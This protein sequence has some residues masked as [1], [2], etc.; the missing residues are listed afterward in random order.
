MQISNEVAKEKARQRAETAR[1]WQHKL[2]M[3]NKEG[4][5]KELAQLEYEKQQTLAKLKDNE[6]ARLD[7]IEYYRKKEAE[8]KEKY[9]K[10][11]VTP[12]ERFGSSEQNMNYWAKDLKQRLEN[13]KTPMDKTLQFFDE[14][15]NKILNAEKTYKQFKNSFVDGLT[16]IVMN[17]KSASDAWAQFRDQLIRTL[18]NQAI[19][20]LINDIAAMGVE[21]KESK[22]GNFLSDIFTAHTGG[23]ITVN[24]IDTFHSGGIVGMKPDE[25]LIKARVGE[26]VLTEEQQKNVASNS[27]QGGNINLTAN[28]S[29]IDSKSLVRLAYENE[30]TFVNVVA[31]NIIKNGQLRSVLKKYL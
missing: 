13:A 15:P 1:K 16:D 17:T 21:G 22:T 26:M 2:E 31:S 4:L 10:E 24:G 23:T 27:Q 6:E 3:I 29:A 9:A 18:A 25:R 11:K 19:M 8:I 30:D 12:G 28:I 14:L 5:E 7:A 20:A